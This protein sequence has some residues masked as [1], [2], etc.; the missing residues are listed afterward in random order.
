MFSALASACLG[1]PEQPIEE[2][3]AGPNR[4][5]V[6]RAWFKSFNRAVKEPPLYAKKR[7]PNPAHTP[8]VAEVVESGTVGQPGYIAPVAAVAPVGLA[9]VLSGFVL[10]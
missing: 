5:A 6:Y 8:G 2:V 10:A 9:G 4:D 7:I 1:E 3:L